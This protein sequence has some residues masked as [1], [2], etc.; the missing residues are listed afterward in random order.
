MQT[1]PKLLLEFF[2]AIYCINLP[3]RTDRWNKVLLEFDKLGIRDKVIRVDG[4]SGQSPIWRGCTL[5]HLGILENSIDNRILIF[6]DDVL[7]I[8]DYC[9]IITGAINELDKMQWSMFYLGGNICGPIIQETQ[10]LGRLSHSQSTH[11]YSIN[12]GTAKKILELGNSILD[13]P[14]DLMYTENIIPLL[15]CYI[16]I[17][18]IAVQNNDYSNIE[19]T[20]VNYT[21][22]MEERF[23]N[24]L[25]KASQ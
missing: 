9:K 21:T 17:P 6:E 11:A 1:T 10:F 15:P 19:R 18:M 3:Q 7:F 13:K 12:K 8:N 23:Y 2:D 24:N 20:N 25:R 4:I 22:W 5:A 14:L 16:T